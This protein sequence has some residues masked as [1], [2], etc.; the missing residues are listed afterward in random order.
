MQDSKYFYDGMPLFKYCEENN[1]NV[2]TIRTRIWKLKHNKKYENYTEQEIINIV[3]E[4]YGR[5]K[6]EYNYKGIPIAKY[7][8]DNGLKI[9]A[10]KSRIKRI[11]DKNSNLSNDEIVILAVDG[12]GKKQYKFFYQGVPLIEYCKNHPELSYPSIKSYITSN[13]MKYPE[14][15]YEELLERYFLREHNETYRYYYEGMP[16]KKYCEENDLDYSRIASF[17][18]YHRNEPEYINLSDDEYARIMLSKYQP[19][20]PKYL[21]NGTTLRNYCI[22]NELSY[23]SVVSFVK[24]KLEKGSNKSIDELIDEGI[25]T[26][27]RYGIIYYYDNIPLIDYCKQN[28]LN[29]SSI[30]CEIIRKCLKDDRP[31]QEIVNQCVESY[32]KFSIKYYYNGVPLFKYCKSIGLNYNTVIHKYL[33]EYCDRKDIDINDAIKEIV[34]YYIEHPPARV[35]Y[36]FNND[37]LFKFCDL[38]GYSYSTIFQRIKALESKDVF[39]EREHIIEEAIKKYEGKLAISK[40]NEIFYILK[41]KNNIDIDEIKEY[42]DFLKI[43]F[44]CVNDIVS[45][46]FSFN[47][48]INMIWYFSDNEDN[49]YKLLTD[50]KLKEIFELIKRLDDNEN[51]DDFELYDLIGIYKSELYDSRY[52]IVMRQRKYISKTIYSLCNEYQ[53]EVNKSNYDDFESEIKYYLL[54]VVDRINLNVYGQIIKYMDLTVKGYFRTYL[55]KSKNYNLSLDDAKFINDKGTK[56][57]KARIDYVVDSN[58]SFD[59]INDSIFSSDMMMALSELSSSDL[60][61]IMLKFQENYSDEELADYFS[62]TLDEVKNKETEILLLL[63]NNNNIKILKKKK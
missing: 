35:K 29:A 1:I 24:R 22:N 57:E 53:I 48:S 52:A 49:N 14:L 55:K 46:G 60:S 25:R 44:D 36:F 19:F 32:Q 16:L 18:R 38:N 8:E 26:I 63:R 23:F 37:S 34:D 30:R 20:S 15:S 54:K 12:Y 42:C 58:N 2:N 5:K 33:D 45:M 56:K 31:L 50:L 41:S 40:I 10:I 47:Q 62:L 27:N 43:N 9:N 39:L 3:I 11:K 59:K 7:C 13:K 61:F 21:Y 17:F 6:E 51:I 28:N 4:K